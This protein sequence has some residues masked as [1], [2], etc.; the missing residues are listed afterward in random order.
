MI[1]KLQTWFI[2]KFFIRQNEKLVKVKGW[3][4]YIVD[5]ISSRRHCWVIFN[6]ATIQHMIKTCF[7]II[8]QVFIKEKDGKLKIPETPV[9]GRAN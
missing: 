1:K 9:H 5:D 6:W 7:L 2:T 4:N 8:K 3:A